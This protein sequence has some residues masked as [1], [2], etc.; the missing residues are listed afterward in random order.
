MVTV[1]FKIETK[2][3]RFWEGTVKLDR[4]YWTWNPY[5]YASVTAHRRHRGKKMEVF[6]TRNLRDNSNILDELFYMACG[7]HSEIFNAEGCAALHA[8]DYGEFGDVVRK[9]LA[10]DEEAFQ[11]SHE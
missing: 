8:V 5:D 4:K 6:F 11:A 2:K 9:A 1:D 3:N 10:L 7:K